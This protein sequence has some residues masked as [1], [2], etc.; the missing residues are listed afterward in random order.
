LVRESSRIVSL[1][2]RTWALAVVVS[3]SK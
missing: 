1:S 2:E 3:E